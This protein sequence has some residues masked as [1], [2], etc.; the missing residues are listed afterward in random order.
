MSE[1]VVGWTA[2]ARIA[3]RVEDRLEGE[4]G[5]AEVMTRPLLRGT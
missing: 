5:A 3:A 2:S 1:S 4:G